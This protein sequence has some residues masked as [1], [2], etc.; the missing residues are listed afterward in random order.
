MEKL[1]EELAKLLFDWIDDDGWE[2]WEVDKDVR[3]HYRNKTDSILSLPSLREALE[4]A[5]KWD[6]YQAELANDKVHTDRFISLMDSEADNLRRDA[7][8]WRKV[9]EIAKRNWT[10]DPCEDCPVA[11][12]C[13]SSNS[14][15]GQADDLIEALSEVPNGN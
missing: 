15:C 2:W 1:R 13:D 6:A 5:E 11:E 14:L 10:D 4:K 3:D 8:K 12:R 9:E 7:E